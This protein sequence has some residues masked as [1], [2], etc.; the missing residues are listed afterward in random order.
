MSPPET[1]TE[2]HFDFFLLIIKKEEEEEQPDRR[3]VGS[4]HEER[5]W[6]QSITLKHAFAM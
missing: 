1:A 6:T 4:A 5:A 2:F 3:C